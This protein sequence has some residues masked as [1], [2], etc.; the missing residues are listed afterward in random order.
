M[1]FILNFIYQIGLFYFTHV[2]EVLLCGC[3]VKRDSGR[4]IGAKKGLTAGRNS[5]H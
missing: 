1:H 5:F 2:N 4:R 3:T